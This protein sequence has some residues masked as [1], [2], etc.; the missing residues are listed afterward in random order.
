MQ[1]V[2]PMAGR[3]ER[4]R[5]AGVSVPKPLISIDGGPM[6]LRA[7][8][9]LSH[10]LEEFHDSIGVTL[11]V[12]R[13]DRIREIFDT[14]FTPP[15]IECSLAWLEI[16]GRTSGPAETLYRAAATFDPEC[17]LVS[18]DCDLYF[19]C[20]NLLRALSG[21]LGAN[22][23]FSCVDG[24][25]GTFES[26]L[27]RYSYVQIKEDIVTEIAE[28]RVISNRAVFGCYAFQRCGDF[29]SSFENVRAI[30]GREYFV[31]HVIADLVKRGRRF[32]TF[33]A[34]RYRSFGTPEECGES[35]SSIDFS[36]DGINSIADET[37]ATSATRECP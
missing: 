16:D 6:F 21:W 27:S 17:A 7:L 28:K 9:S 12:S 35:D 24:F 26:N 37:F 8:E 3:G 20:P 19:Q 1:V 34:I 11:V 4:F 31:S 10:L 33:P 13:E 36:A 22:P 25:L 15:Q 23:E 18:L 32:Q 5:Q 29:V 14:N 2:L 30:P